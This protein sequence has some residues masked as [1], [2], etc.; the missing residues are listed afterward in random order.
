MASIDNI[1]QFILVITNE[2]M[3]R[4]CYETSDGDSGWQLKPFQFAISD[5]DVLEGYSDDEIFNED[6]TVKP[7]I[8]D[9]LQKL[10]TSN[11]NADRENIWCQLPFSGV[12]KID[13]KGDTLSHHIVIPADLAI[14]GDSKVVKTIY[15]LYSDINGNNFLY[16]IAR[17]NTYIVYE[18]GLTQK[19][20]FN[21]TVSNADEQAVTKFV[22]NYSYPLEIQDHNTSTSSE[23]HPGLLAR[24]ASRPVDDT[25]YYSLLPDFNLDPKPEFQELGITKDMAIVDK[26]YVDNILNIVRDMIEDIKEELTVTA[27][28]PGLCA[29]WPGAANTVPKSWAIRNGQQV[30]ISE[31]PKLYSIIGTK[32]NNGTESPGYFRLM[33]DLGL[34]IRGY[35]NNLGVGLGDVQNENCTISIPYSGW[36]CANGHGIATQGRLMAA[37]G[38]SEIAEF[39]ESIGAVNASQRVSGSNVRPKNRNYLP[40]I[41][42]G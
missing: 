4:V 38:R 41:R 36:S 28:P 30:K 29:W 37:S 32:Y 1:D 8:Y 17:A 42:L 21:F 15:Y 9:L 31:N 14:T 23:I 16:A 10:T 19:Y 5:T 40:I 34:F 6:G 7:E 35:A 2:A 24:D 39:L 33:N 12:T 18:K 27:S 20:F 13:S 3:D 11:M 22:V 26:A 25:M